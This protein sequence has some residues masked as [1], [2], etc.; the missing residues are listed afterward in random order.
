[1]NSDT[2]D[3]ERRIDKGKARARS[4]EPTEDTPLLGSASGSY[5]SRNEPE[6]L[7]RRLYSRLVSVFLISLSFCVLA[8]IFVVLIVYSYRSRAV[9]ASPDQILQHALVLRGP[10]GVDVL[11]ST[12]D[13]GVWLLVRGRIGLDAGE[14]AGVNTAVGDNILQDVWKSLGRWSIR[15]LDRVSV[16][17]TTIEITSQSDPSHALTTIT[18]PP[19]ELPLTANPPPDTTWLTPVEVPILLRPTKDMA[20]LKRFVRDSWREGRIEVQAVVAQAIVQGGGLDESSW[21]RQLKVMHSDIHTK[22]HITS[23]SSLV[24]PL[25]FSK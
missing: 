8:F 21:R 25:L 15:R 14:V 20:T 9:S 6:T 13:G 4:P 7:P 22:I 19:L 18:L 1:M 12:G 24:L 10:D 3:V 16:N 23:V 5:T 2:A 11:N 17:L